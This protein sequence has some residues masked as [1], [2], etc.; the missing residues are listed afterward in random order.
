MARIL[1]AD[2]RRE[3]TCGTRHTGGAV[4]TSTVLILCD[5]AVASALLGMLAEI[6]GFTPAFAEPAE[7]PEDAVERIRPVFVVL[8]DASLDA[9]R[10]DLFFSRAARRGLGIAVL[11]RPGQ[12][13]VLAD[14]AVRRDVPCFEVPSDAD[15]LTRVVEAASACAPW[16]KG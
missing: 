12:Q 7:G 6:A 5:D 4:H 8:L 15:Q 13:S 10:S 2:A 9:A 11:R 14:W 1:I 3:R 16:R